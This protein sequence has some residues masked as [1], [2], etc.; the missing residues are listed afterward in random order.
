MAVESTMLELGTQAPDFALPDTV[1]G[2][3]VRLADFAESKALV[4][5]FVANHCPYV[6][7]I[8]QGLVALGRDY[9]NTGTAI[10]AIGS[11]DVVAYPEDAPEELGRVAQELGYTFPVLFDESQDTAGAYAAA[12]TPDFFLFGPDMALVYRGRLDSS[13]PGSEVPVTGE[14]LRAAIDALL[15]GEPVAEVQY[16]S[17]G[18]SIKWKPG[19]VPVAF[20]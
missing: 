16:P 6:K 3:T 8:Q 4:V 11:N 18:C 1:T 9:E 17:T 14:D 13:R 12:C 10:V 2:E 7:H 20:G 5:V 19:N 15:A